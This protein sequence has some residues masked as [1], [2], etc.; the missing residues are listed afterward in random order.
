MKIPFDTALWVQRSLLGLDGEDWSVGYIID[1]IPIVSNHDLG[2]WQLGVDLIYRT[3]T[4]EL[5]GIDVFVE[6]RDKTSFLQAIGTVSPYENSGGFLWNG[7]RIYGTDRLSKL[8]TDYFSSTD[9]LDDKLNPA[10][11][12]A[13]EQIFAENSVPWSE[14][15]LL[16]ITPAGG[17]VEAAGQS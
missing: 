14:K 4:C 3:L 2:R 8:I 7:T 17:G 10:F 13:L 9:E 15:P 11:I 1:R 6:C 16:P 5:I 12:E